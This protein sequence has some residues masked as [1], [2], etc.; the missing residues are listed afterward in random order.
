MRNEYHVRDVTTER[1]KGVSMVRLKS[2]VLTQIMLTSELGIDAMLGCYTFVISNEVLSSSSHA[3]AS[4]WHFIKISLGELVYQRL[5][6]P[7]ITGCNP[8]PCIHISFRREIWKH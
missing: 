7:G 4:T 1:K 2:S 5:T 3:S 8:F 6:I